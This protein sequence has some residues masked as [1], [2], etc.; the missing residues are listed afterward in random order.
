MS[1]IKID[2]EHEEWNTVWIFQVNPK[3]YDIISALNDGAL[4]SWRISQHRYRIKKG[5]LALIWMSGKQSGIYGIARI[6]SDPE[7]KKISFK[8]NK[9]AIDMKGDVEALAVDIS[10]IRNLK[11][12]PLLKK[13]MVNLDEMKNLS[14]IQ[15]PRAT[16]YPVTD[17]QWKVIARML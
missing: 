8:D 7:L 2:K 14:V 3:K 12:K 11:D 5:H 1:T 6:D 13:D 4:N 15:M 16:N 17:A 10:L 9:Y